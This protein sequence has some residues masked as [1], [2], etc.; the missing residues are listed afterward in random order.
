MRS[1]FI[2]FALIL[3]AAC[4]DVPWA[5]EEVPIAPADG[6]AFPPGTTLAEGLDIVAA[7]V[8]SAIASGLDETGMRQLYRAEALSDRVFET[9]LPF[10]WLAGQNYRLE[11]RVW[12]LQARADRIVARLRA[13]A[14]REDVLPETEALRR[15]IAGLRAAIGEG[16]ERPPESIDRL[17]QRLDSVTRRRS[18]DPAN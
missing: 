4:I 1:R 14:R 17:L 7:V 8:D 6:N 10:G 2:P 5:R 15:D 11:A 3:F 16:G 12:Q 13:G 9:A 18:T